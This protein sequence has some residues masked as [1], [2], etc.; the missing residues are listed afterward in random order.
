MFERTILNSLVHN[1]EYSR[2]VLP[3]LKSEYFQNKSESEVFKLI[4]DYI[5]KYNKLP[6]AA[7]VKSELDM[8]ESNINEFEY[9]EM[10]A[11][12]SDLAKKGDWELP[13]LVDKTEVF[14]KEKAIYNGILESVAILKD[15]T[16]K[17]S[18][19]IIP[20]ILTDALGVSFD[21]HV[22]LD[23][24]EDAD[25]WFD[26]IHQPHER[27][28][29]DIDML[30][31]ITKGGLRKKTLTMLIGGVGFGKSLWMC[32]MAGANLLQGKKVLYISMEMSEDQ[33]SE[34]VYANMLNIPLDQLDIIPKDIFSKKVQALKAK[35]P[36]KLITHEYPTSG[37]GANNFRHLLNELKIKKNFIP[38]I[39]YIDYINICLSNRVKFSGSMNMYTYIKFIAEEIRALAKEYDVPIVSATQINREGFVSSDPGMENVSE[40]FGLAATA[41]LILII[42]IS[43]ELTRLSQYMIKQVK[44]RYN[45]ININNKFVVGVDKSKMRLFNVENGAQNLSQQK[46]IAPTAPNP[47]AQPPMTISER[48][49]AG[50]KKPGFNFKEFK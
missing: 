12:V 35:T 29:F 34:R 4:S 21:N 31:K 40:S 43:E 49:M 39:I 7:T 8:Q 44:N 5:V 50:V 37:A 45:D 20:Q 47:D 27:L 46:F 16:G 3:Y 48:A 32:H 1:E 26:R 30:N 33:V 11:I 18:T 10:S 9:K 19:A 24:I 23:L 17:T 22:G 41:D 6:T 13:W 36:G 42:I 2:K 25:E 28:P 15:K 14:C 38:D